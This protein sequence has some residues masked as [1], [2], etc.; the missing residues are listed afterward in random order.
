MNEELMNGVIE[1]TTENAVGSV[2]E[3]AVK[4]GFFEKFGKLSFF[5]LVGIGIYKGGKF[6]C[7]MIKNHKKASGEEEPEIVVTEA[8]EEE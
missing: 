2:A 4:S 5:A 1:E 3:E 7:N 8:T 6:V